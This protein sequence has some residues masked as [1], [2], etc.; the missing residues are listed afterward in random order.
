[1]SATVSFSD[2]PERVWMVKNSIYEWFVP[3][4][5][6]RCRSAQVRQ[7]LQMS[8]FT[9]GL[10]IPSTADPTDFDAS[11]LVDVLR[12]VAIDVAEGRED[13]PTDGRGS[14]DTRLSTMSHFRDL[15][16]MIDELRQS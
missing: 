6:D 10:V 11:E 15:A 9:N 16:S 1:M 8:E 14:P 2:Y 4:V 12:C 7:V 5:M 3:L 13:L